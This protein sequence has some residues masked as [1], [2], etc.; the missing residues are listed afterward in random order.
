MIVSFK[1]K[2]FS[3]KNAHSQSLGIEEVACTSHTL[4]LS[5][6]EMIGLALVINLFIAPREGM[7]DAFVHC[8]IPHTQIQHGDLQQ[9]HLLNIHRIRLNP[10]LNQQ[11]PTRSQLDYRVRHPS[12]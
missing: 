8:S 1:T 3:G 2:K 11:L 4:I 5:I 12:L 10:S 7:P 6:P 9:R